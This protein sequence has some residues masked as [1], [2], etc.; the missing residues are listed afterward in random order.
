M[1]RRAGTSQIVVS[2]LPTRPV[3][4]LLI[5]VRVYALMTLHRDRWETR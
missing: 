3:H 5:V 1:K 4:L 2:Q